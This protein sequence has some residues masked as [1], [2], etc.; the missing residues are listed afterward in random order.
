MKAAE[1][2][3][4]ISAAEFKAEAVLGAIRGGYINTLVADQKLAVK[5]LELLAKPR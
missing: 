3:I 4:G 2:S 1:W 5:L